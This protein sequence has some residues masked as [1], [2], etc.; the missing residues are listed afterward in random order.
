MGYSWNHCPCSENHIYLRKM[1]KKFVFTPVAYQMGNWTKTIL[2]RK[3]LASTGIELVLFRR[4]VDI[5]EN[6][7]LL[8]VFMFVGS[9]L[10]R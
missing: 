1:A 4:D 8:A 10:K 3:P 5:V 6:E 9:R 2:I 7:I